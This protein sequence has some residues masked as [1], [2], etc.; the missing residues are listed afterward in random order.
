MSLK[1]LKNEEII[2]G[3]QHIRPIK[4]NA[5]HKFDWMPFNGVRKFKRDLNEWDVSWMQQKIHLL[6]TN[7]FCTMISYFILFHFSNNNRKEK[8][9]DLD[10][11]IFNE[12]EKTLILFWKLFFFSFWFH[13]L[14]WTFIR[15]LYCF[16]HYIIY[17]F[18]LCFVVE[19]FLAQ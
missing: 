3:P 8:F 10:R 5:I 17:N 13:T 6:L 4:I 14:C 11:P 9:F 15:L 7:S 12:N 2:Y 16:Y 19:F 18:F 1:N